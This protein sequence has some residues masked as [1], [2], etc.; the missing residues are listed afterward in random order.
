[1]TLQLLKLLLLH[2][3]NGIRKMKISLKELLSLKSS[4]YVRWSLKMEKR[5]IKVCGV[6][7]GSLIM[8]LTMFHLNVNFLLRL[9]YL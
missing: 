8:I 6:M 2:M 1:M 4:K 9:N 5:C 3:Q 7:M